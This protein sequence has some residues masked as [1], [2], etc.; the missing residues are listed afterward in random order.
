M[1]AFNKGVD[2]DGYPILTSPGWS[3]RDGR[4]TF[5]AP[6]GQLQSLVL[7]LNMKMDKPIVDATGLKGTYEIVMHWA[8]STL[9][10]SGA[11]AQAM[12]QAR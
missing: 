11:L 12:A 8:G 6:H 1:K 5:Y 10:V 7:F 3:T 9:P 4:G 2:K